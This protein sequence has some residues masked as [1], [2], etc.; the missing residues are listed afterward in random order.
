MSRIDF[1]AIQ[2]SPVR[3]ERNMQAAKA[4]QIADQFK[5]SEE[6]NTLLAKCLSEVEKASKRGEYATQIIFTK[7]NSAKIVLKKL[8]DLGYLTSDPPKSAFGGFESSNEYWLTISW[9]HA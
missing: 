5:D 9:S 3:A 7:G 2:N 4:K 6:V 8:S 1:D